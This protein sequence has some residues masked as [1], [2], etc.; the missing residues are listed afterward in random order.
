[1]AIRLSNH[2]K[3]LYTNQQGMCA[4]EFI[5]DVRPFQKTAGIEAIDVAK[6]LQVAISLFFPFFWI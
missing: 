3:I 4:H 6:R 1:M 5:I 2:Y